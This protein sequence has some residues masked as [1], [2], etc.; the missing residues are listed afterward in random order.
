MQISVFHCTIIAT[1]T[2][3]TFERSLYT[4]VLTSFMVKGS[5]QAER[6]PVPDTTF[7]PGGGGG[8]RNYDL[9]S[10]GGSNAPAPYLGWKHTR[11]SSP[12][13]HTH[14]GKA[15]GQTAGERE[16][17]FHNLFC[18]Q[19]YIVDLLWKLCSCRCCVMSTR[20]NIIDNM[21]E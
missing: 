13:P 8:R 14:L 19:I 7:I 17:G 15:S 9:S 3:E 4:Y 16:M 12:V 2:E 6:M 18:F 1:Y 21:N 11:D 5:V 20:I 10:N